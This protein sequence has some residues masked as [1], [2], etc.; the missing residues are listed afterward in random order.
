M[1]DAARRCH[2]DLG[3]EA[4]SSAALIF[5]RAGVQCRS[6]EPLSSSIRCVEQ[7]RLAH[8][9]SRDGRYAKSLARHTG[10]AAFVTKIEAAAGST[11]L[12]AARTSQACCSVSP[13]MSR[14]LPS[15]RSSVYSLCLSPICALEWN[16]V[17]SKG[18]NWILRAGSTRWR[19]TL[20]YSPAARMQLSL[21]TANFMNCGSRV[22]IEMSTDGFSVLVN[23]A[24]AGA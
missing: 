19:I 7:R 11:R 2:L 13:P 8:L 12:Y 15:P 22:S 20:E 9:W 21:P 6:P 14:H 1:M 23:V 18:C 24:T 5:P 10:E 3:D 16:L 4:G 17:F